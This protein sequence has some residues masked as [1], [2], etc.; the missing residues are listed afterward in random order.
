LSYNA[1]YVQTDLWVKDRQGHCKQFSKGIVRIPGT[2]NQVFDK[3]E[4]ERV[5][6]ATRLSTVDVTYDVVGCAV[7]ATVAAEVTHGEFYGAMTAHT[8]RSKR[9][10]VLFDSQVGGDNCHG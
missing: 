5:S 7:E 1:D 8:T 10:I 6:L 9:R 3:C 4:P 2:A